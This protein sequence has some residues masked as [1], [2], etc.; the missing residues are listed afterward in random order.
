[1]TEDSR[2]SLLGPTLGTIAFVIV[3]PGTVIVWVPYVLTGD[4]TVA[5]PLFPGARWLGGLLIAAGLPIF[6]DFLVRFVRDGMGTPAPIAP[7]RE[8]VV[9]GTFRYCRNPGYVG[10]I[11]LIAGQA[12]IFGAASVLIYAACAWLVFHLFVRLYEEPDLR[13]RFGSTYEDY[14]RQV[15][16]WIPRFR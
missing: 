2:P 1:V 7:P 10:V 15:P 5:P 14:R 6:G 3:V 13:R 9:R 16:R 12:F 4:W 8:L 11:A